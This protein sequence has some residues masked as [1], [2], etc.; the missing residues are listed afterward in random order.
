MGK[1]KKKNKE[2]KPSKPSKP[3]VTDKKPT[4]TGLS[5]EQSRIELPNKEKTTRLTKL[6]QLISD[7]GI[8]ETFTNNVSYRFPKLKDSIF[9]K[10]GY[11]VQCDLLML[12]ETPQKY[13]YLLTCIDLWSNYC[14]FEPMK[15]KTAESTLNALLEILKRK[16]IHEIIASCRTDS[17]GEFKGAFQEWLKQHNIYHSTT[18]PDRHKQTGSVENLNRFIARILLTYLAN[19]KR[20]TGKV[21]TD[22]IDILEKTR[23]AINDFKKHRADQN[24]NTYPMK[25]IDIDVPPKFKVGDLVYHKIEIAK[26]E[27]GKAFHHSK[28][29]SGDE[30]YSDEARKIVKEVVYP[31][32][33]PYRYILN[34]IPDVAYAEAELILANDKT[35]ETW[36]IR[37]IIGKR[38]VN[39]KVFYLVW[40][41]K[42]LKKEATWEPKERL[43]KDDAGDYIKEYEDSLKIQKN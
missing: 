35:E 22:W 21:Y 37:K 12:P 1:P 18:L 17:G 2:V 6:Q 23:V 14:D 38:T 31:S 34:G 4:T 15:L 42:D 8:D 10:H 26:D 36:Y 11:N 33:N 30:R 43:L 28:F 16:Y 5:Q 32:K 40:W 13:R 41:K 19:M 20:K 7:L 39:K 25:E 27:Y 24:P 3:K 9:P 29:R